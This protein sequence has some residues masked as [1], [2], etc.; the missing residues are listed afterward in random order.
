MGGRVQAA[1]RS[2]SPFSAAAPPPR[3]REGT[4]RKTATVSNRLLRSTAS[5]RGKRRSFMQ[6][7]PQ[8]EQI[9][10]RPVRR[11]S[12]SMTQLP[13]VNAVAKRVLSPRG[14]TPSRPE[15]PAVI[16]AELED[17]TDHSPPST[18]TAS[19]ESSAALAE[20]KERKR[21]EREA[22]RQER[23]A[24]MADIEQR[25]QAALA[26]VDAEPSVDLLAP[27][28]A[29]LSRAP[30]RKNSLAAPLS[31]EVMTVDRL[32]LLFGAQ[33]L[34]TPTI[35]SPVQQ[36]ERFHV[37]ISS[38]ILSGPAIARFQFSEAPRFSEFQFSM[39][40][41]TN[42][43]LAALA[44]R[45]KGD[46]Q[47]VSLFLCSGFSNEGVQALGAFSNLG[48]F[49]I[50]GCDGPTAAGVCLMLQT[51]SI[52][53]KLQ[54]LEFS[55]LE[56]SPDLIE[57][58]CKLSR[59]NRLHIANC[60]GIS[61]TDFSK[62]GKLPLTE[63]SV[64]G[65]PIK[66]DSIGCFGP[67][68]E[69]LTPVLISCERLQVL[70]LT[71]FKFDNALFQA[72]LQLPLI[73]L[74]LKD[75]E[76]LS[77]EQFQ[78]LAAISTMQEFSHEECSFDDDAESESSVS[79]APREAFSNR[80]APPSYTVLLQFLQ[81]QPSTSTVQVEEVLEKPGDLS[82]PISQ[83]YQAR[84]N[85]LECDW[86]VPID[87]TQWEAIERA[88]QALKAPPP[89][90]ADSP[91]ES[92][93]SGNASADDTPASDSEP[94]PLAPAQ[95]ARSGSGSLAPLVPLS[96]AATADR[97]SSGE[98]SD[99]ESPPPL[100]MPLSKPPSLSL[101]DREKEF[102]FLVGFVRLLPQKT[103]LRAIFERP[104]SWADQVGEFYRKMLEGRGLLFLGSITPENWLKVEQ[105]LQTYQPP[106]FCFLDYNLAALGAAVNRKDVLS[107]VSR[108]QAAISEFYAAQLK[109]RG[110]ED[111]V[112]CS[113]VNGIKIAEQRL[114]AL[115]DR[116]ILEAFLAAIGSGAGSIQ[117]LAALYFYFALDKGARD[118]VQELNLR[119]QRVL[120]LPKV[121]EFQYPNLRKADLSGNGI[122]ELS[123]FLFPGCDKLHTLELGNNQLQS[124]PDY[125][126][127]QLS[128]LRCL[129]L[130]RNKIQQFPLFR[131]ERKIKGRDL[132][133][134]YTHLEYLNLTGNQIADLS[135]TEIASLTN[136]P[137][138]VI[139][140][141]SGNPICDH[142]DR[143]AKVAAACPNVIFDPNTFT[144]LDFHEQGLEIFPSS[145]AQN[146][147]PAL[148]FINL[149]RNKIKRIP[150]LDP[151]PNLVVLDLSYNLFEF[152][153][154]EELAVLKALPKTCL[155]DLSGNP[156][157]TMQLKKIQGQL[158]NVVF[159]IDMPGGA[160]PQFVEEDGKEPS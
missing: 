68:A 43:Q 29:R 115:H 103:E 71:G 12:P 40:T 151:R 128:S 119:E 156:L 42:D 79:S 139:V 59:L 33:P 124:L 100:V 19:T 108:Y 54:S 137:R 62:L 87:S 8:S 72:L 105:L 2:G 66:D 117:N 80:P 91:N 129:D 64:T 61:D 92:E 53:D 51:P 34:A 77:R 89:S 150:R 141:L 50:S 57:V 83:H 21:R 158:P 9:I 97:L 126:G 11:K 113:S 63:L 106:T 96:T 104:H 86:S 102:H 5:S 93:Y 147:Y 131:K 55:S 114:M 136:L 23:L 56:F 37:P 74:Q 88:L 3:Q 146:K 144:S 25:T 24:M 18:A 149:S 153:T 101:L 60:Q 154:D 152:L 111:V 69:G 122:R 98:S 14:A 157:S 52:Q 78:Q 109:A 140:D 39:A 41:I 15:F 125:F 107:D 7:K 46:I 112:D 143:V 121:F 67:T 73:R 95:Q 47:G 142:P 85:E 116:P 123:P 130:R 49:S 1:A 134:L 16:I 36:D 90:R 6:P 20:A 48:S 135:P 38:I 58:I 155:I 99:S 81:S 26:M 82:L 28:S 65:Y 76:D 110:V 148:Q 35:S 22:K 138:R 94:S 120:L 30:S 13:F 32:N 70:E 4:E 84:L 160:Q 45:F 127:E 10:G 17:E 31:N 133:P 27:P 44:N 132:E 75:C 118:Q 145:I 159:K